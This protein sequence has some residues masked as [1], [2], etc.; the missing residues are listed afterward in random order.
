[1]AENLLTKSKNVFSLKLPADIPENLY[2][3]YAELAMYLSLV[4]TL[5]NPDVYGRFNRMPVFQNTFNGLKDILS[6]VIENS[7]SIDSFQDMIKI[8]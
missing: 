2:P 3:K 1:M 6:D 5:G 4:K 8:L 7:T